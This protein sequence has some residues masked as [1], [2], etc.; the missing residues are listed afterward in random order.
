MLR[1]LSILTILELDHFWRQNENCLLAP[2]WK[3]TFLKNFWIFR[4]MI[5]RFNLFDPDKIV[6]IVNFLKSQF[7]GIGIK[8]LWEK[9]IKEE[10]CSDF[11]L[12]WL[13]WSWTTFGAK[14]KIDFWRQN[15][16][17]LLFCQL[18]ALSRYYKSIQFI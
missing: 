2:K 7:I 11:C 18:L 12:F 5:N 17:W 4:D 1:F 3:L 10:R 6:K 9:F 13:F 15:E 14:M 8:L 16:D